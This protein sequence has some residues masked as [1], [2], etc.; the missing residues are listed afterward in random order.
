[1]KNSISV[2]PIIK[3]GFPGFF[4]PLLILAAII[5][6]LAL[7]LLGAKQP[8]ILLAVAGII[9]MILLLYFRQDEL[10]ATT[11]LVVS[12]YIDWYLSLRVA[13]LI[14]ILVLLCVFFLARSPQHPW[15]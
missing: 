7:G 8:Y 14:L 10:A 2:R 4:L 6:L 15:G 11:V 1:M 5:A 9:F 13:A 3:E 12:L